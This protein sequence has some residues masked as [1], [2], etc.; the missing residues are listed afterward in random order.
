MVWEMVLVLVMIMIM[1]TMLMLATDDDEDFHA[2]MSN[3]LLRACRLGTR[4]FQLRYLDP[5]HFG[6]SSL[7]QAK[8]CLSQ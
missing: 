7:K 1:M 2:F 8:W 6:A 4:R 3:L 5:W